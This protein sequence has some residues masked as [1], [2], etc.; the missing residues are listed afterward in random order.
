MRLWSL[1]EDTT[2]QKTSAR[3]SCAALRAAAQLHKWYELR[4]DG[5]RNGDCGQATPAA[6][7]IVVNG[8]TN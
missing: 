2:I 1:D 6:G 7:D 4:E 3:A 5:A 8:R